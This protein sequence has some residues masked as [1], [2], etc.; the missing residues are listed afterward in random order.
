MSSK[1][2]GE[3]HIK[4]MCKILIKKKFNWVP[5]TEIISNDHNV[6]KSFNNK[7]YMAVQ[8]ENINGYFY[9]RS[10]WDSRDKSIIITDSY[11]TNTDGWKKWLQSKKRHEILEQYKQYFAVD[12]TYNHLLDR[13]PFDVPLL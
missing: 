6:I 4:S 9:S 11:W 3:T 10:Y 8:K 7:L 5:G 12:T 1:I 2:L 13:E